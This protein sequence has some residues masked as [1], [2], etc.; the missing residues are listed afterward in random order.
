MIWYVTD[1]DSAISTY[2]D[3]LGF[4]NETLNMFDSL[5]ITTYYNCISSLNGEHKAPPGA[6]IREIN[7][8][9]CHLTS[10]TLQQLPQLA[11][12]ERLNLD[13]CQDVDDEAVGI[14]G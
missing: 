6:S 9:F 13:G 12:L 1:T 7:A 2:M 4:F 14:Y 10:A 3:F 8:S 11:A 5:Y